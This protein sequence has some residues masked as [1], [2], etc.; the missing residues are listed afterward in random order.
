MAFES[1]VLAVSWRD[2]TYGIVEKLEVD[3][4]NDLDWVALE[5]K[6]SWHDVSQNSSYQDFAMAVSAPM[7]QKCAV[8]TA[9]KDFFTRTSDAH[10]FFYLIHRAEWESGFGD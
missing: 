8:G 9:A 5:A 3:N 7:F 10:T 6:Y 1:F 2:G 4:R